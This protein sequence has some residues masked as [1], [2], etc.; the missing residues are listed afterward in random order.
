MPKTD[1]SLVRQKNKPS[2]K[3]RS[4]K[5]KKKAVNMISLIN[6]EVDYHYSCLTELKVKIGEL[7]QAAFDE[8]HKVRD[9]QETGERL[10]DDQRGEQSTSNLPEDLAQ[11]EALGGGRIRVGQEM[12]PLDIEMEKLLLIKKWLEDHPASG[13]GKGTPA[14]GADVVV[15]ARQNILVVDDDPT[16]V[17]ILTHFL[18]RENY[19]V[20]SAHSGAEGLEKAFQEKPCLI[21]LDIMIPDLNGFQF[22][23]LL[24]KNKD[25]ASVPVILLSMLAEEADILKGLEIGAVDYVTKPFSPPIIAAK[26]KKYMS[27]AK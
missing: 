12:N 18:E 6:K 17:K 2:S 16:T 9:L 10:K 4:S 7:I 24:R 13:S 15:P 8:L 19:I 23:S 3:A 1:S 26:I 21:L 25:L 11:E 14:A 20:T 5:S 27:L 22:L